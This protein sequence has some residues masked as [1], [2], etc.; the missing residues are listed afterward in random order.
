MENKYDVTVYKLKLNKDSRISSQ[1]VVVKLT[2][3][4]CNCLV[5]I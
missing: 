4:Q 2:R 1:H 3:K 5:K